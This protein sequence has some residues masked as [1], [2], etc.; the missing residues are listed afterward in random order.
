[1]N[2]EI[3]N[4]IVDL[5]GTSVVSSVP[6]ECQRLLSAIIKYSSSEG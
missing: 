3:L 1:M 2:K 4:K 5:S 6:S